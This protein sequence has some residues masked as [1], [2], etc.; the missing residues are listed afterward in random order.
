VEYVMV[1]STHTHAGPDI[2][3]LWTPPERTVDAGYVARIRAQAVEAVAEAWARRRPARLSFASARLPQLIEDSRLPRVIDDLALMMK[4]DAADGRS[5]IATLV[6]FA[7]HPESLG[8]ENNLISSDYP[9]AT[10]RALEER[11]GGT[12]IFFSADIGGLLTPLDAGDL[13]DPDTGRPV[14]RKS[15]R[16]TELLGQV[17][18][19]ALGDAWSGGAAAG[20]PP[21]RVERAALEIRAREFRVPL[22]NQRFARGLSEGHLWPRER[23]AEGALRSEAAVLSVLAEAVQGPPAGDPVT[24]GARLATRAQF[25]CVPGEIYP[26]LVIGGIQDPQD[27]GADIQKAPREPALR[28]L[29]AGRARFVLGLCNDEL[30]Y[31]IPMSEWDEQPPFAYGRTGPQYGEVN[32]TGPRTA[33]IL[34][35]LFADLLR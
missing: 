6:D 17:I 9:G 12:S 23:D 2:L 30:G 1:P 20:A 21:D 16:M 34:L 4:V 28:S 25:A 33:P 13:L 18:A 22:A 26:E 5:T 14:P 8:R 29:M 19:R 15:Y 10:R 27:P 35:D 3:G 32:S 24:A 11:F 7:D 31:I